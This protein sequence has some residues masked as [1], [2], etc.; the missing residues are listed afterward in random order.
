MDNSDPEQE[1]TNIEQ[2]IDDFKPENVPVKKK[3]GGW[4]KGRPRKPAVKS[5]N[6]ATPVPFVKKRGRPRK[7]PH[8][9]EGSPIEQNGNT[10]GDQVVIHV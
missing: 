9:S 7:I 6:L 1:L 2:L 5:P 10:V 4:P 8:E 3:R